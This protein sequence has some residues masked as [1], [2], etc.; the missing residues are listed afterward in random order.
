MIISSRVTEIIIHLLVN[1]TKDKT[2]QVRKFNIKLINLTNTEIKQRKI[3][4]VL[5]YL[6]NL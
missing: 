3:H 6:R 1:L 4:Q 2:S 5:N